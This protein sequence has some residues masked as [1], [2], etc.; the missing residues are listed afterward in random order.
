MICLTVGAS[1]VLATMTWQVSGG[2]SAA[3]EGAN[4]AERAGAHSLIMTAAYAYIDA[5]S[6]T[7]APQAAAGGTTGA[8]V[9]KAD[10]A[11]D[12]A[13]F[14]QF[15]RKCLKKVSKRRNAKLVHVPCSPLQGHQTEM[16]ATADTPAGHT[17]KT[18]VHRPISLSARPPQQQ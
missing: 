8:R 15:E 11:S 6:A 7:M 13:P 4:A 3:S 10:D 17:R 5:R 12:V 9:T 16:I 2:A 1:S 18:P 14:A